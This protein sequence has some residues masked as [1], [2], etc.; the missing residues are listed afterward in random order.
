MKVSYGVSRR[1]LGKYAIFALLLCLCLTVSAAFGAFGFSSQLNARAETGDP[2]ACTVLSAVKVTKNDGYIFTEGQ[3][4]EN[5]I[6]VVTVTVTYKTPDGEEP[7][8]EETRA[9]DLIYNGGNVTAAT[10]EAVA[11]DLNTADK[12]LTA[13]VTPAGGDAVTGTLENITISSASDVAQVGITAKYVGGGGLTTTSVGNITSTDLAVK[14]LMSDGTTGSAL[15]LNADY[16]LG[17]LFPDKLPLENGNNTYNKNLEI[18]T[19]DNKY[20][21]TAFIGGITFV[22]PSSIGTTISGALL[23]QAARSTKLNVSGLSISVNY[24]SEEYWDTITVPL[25]VFDGDIDNENTKYYTYI[26]HATPTNKTDLGLTRKAKFC[27]ITFTYPY[28]IDGNNTATRQNIQLTVAAIAIRT[29]IFPADRELSF[30]DG[31]SYTIQDTDWSSEISGEQPKPDVLVSS[32]PLPSAEEKYYSVENYTVTFLRANTIYDIVLKLP[33]D[34]DFMWR[35]CAEKQDDYTLMCTVTVDKAYVLLA[36]DVPTNITWCYGE[37]YSGSNIQAKVKGNTTFE[38]YSFTTQL[39]NIASTSESGKNT[40]DND[41]RYH[42]E[43]Y[44]TDVNDRVTAYPTQAGKYKAIYVTH[45][46]EI[47][48]SSLDC[49]DEDKANN[50]KE[51]TVTITPIVIDSGNILIGDQTYARSSSYNKTNILNTAETG[52]FLSEDGLPLIVTNNGSQ[53]FVIKYY[54]NDSGYPVKLTLTNNNY[55]WDSIH[56][57]YYTETVKTNRD[58]TKQFK[59]K[60]REI[61]VI[62]PTVVDGGWTYGDPV[63]VANRFSASLSA[64]DQVY[65]TV[66][67]AYFKADGTAQIEADLSA[68]QADSY[69]AVFTPTAKNTVEESSLD[70]IPSDNVTF[71]V[72]KVQVNTITLSENYTV[73][74]HAEHDVTLTGWRLGVKGEQILS[75]T[76]SG[77]TFGDAAIAVTDTASDGSFAVTAAGT[78]TIT[79]SLTDAATVNYEWA[80]EQSELT[81]TVD[82]AP[83]ALFNDSDSIDFDESKTQQDMPVIL[84]KKAV[85]ENASLSESELKLAFVITI[86][87]VPVTELKTSGT[88]IFTVNGISGTEADNYKIDESNKPFFTYTINSTALAIP[89]LSGITGNEIEKPFNGNSYDFLTF[90]TAY[91]DYVSGGITRVVFTVDG[92]E[93]NLGVRDVKMNEDNTAV[94]HYVIYVKPATSYKWAS[95]DETKEYEFH[96][97]VTQLVVNIS[98]GTEVTFTYDGNTA[99]NP[100]YTFVNNADG[101]DAALSI[102][103]GK[104]DAGEYTASIT[105]ITG[106]KAHNY[107]LTGAQNTERAFTV[108]KKLVELSYNI[109]GLTFTGAQQSVVFDGMDLLC[110][111]VSGAV[112]SARNDDGSEFTVNTFKFVHAGDYT[113]KFTLD[114]AASKNY[115]FTADKQTAFSNPELTADVNIAVA[116]KGLLAPVLGAQRAIEHS[117]DGAAKPNNIVTGGDVDGVVYTVTYGEYIGGV[118]QE[119]E[120]TTTLREHTYFIKLVATSDNNLVAGATFDI[121]DY[122]WKENKDDTAKLEFVPERRYGEASEDGKALY[123][124]FAVTK[125]QVGAIFEFK[126]Y[127]YGAN[128]YRESAEDRLTLDKTVKLQDLPASIVEC[129]PSPLYSDYFDDIVAANPDVTFTFVGVDD[130]QLVNGLPWGVDT[131]TVKIS[132]DFGNADFNDFDP[133]ATLTVAPR[134]IQVTW[135]AT[136]TAMYNGRTQYRG[137]TITNLAQKADGVFDAAPELVMTG[138]KDVVYSGDDIAYG[139]TVITGVKDENSCY[140][141]SADISADFKITRKT[142]KVRGNAVASHMYGD[143]IAAGEKDYTVIEEDGNEFYEKD[144]EF[145]TVDIL[146]SDGTAVDYLTDVG[147]YRVVPRLKTVNGNYEL[148]VT[149][150]IFTIVKRN[151]SVSIKTDGSGNTLATSVYG[152][153]LVELNSDD[154]PVYAVGG[155]GLPR[156]VKGSAVFAFSCAVDKFSAVGN[157]PITCTLTENGAKNYELAVFSADYVLAAAEITNISVSGYSNV[158]DASEHNI[159]TVSATT[160]NPESGEVNA[161]VWEYKLA[162]D[163]DEGWKPYTVADGTANVRIKDYNGE[164]GVDYNVRV[165]ASNH[166]PVT[167][168]QLYNVAVTKARLTV[169]VNISIYY[170]EQDP[171]TLGGTGYKQ[172]LA[173]VIDGNGIY[174]VGEFKG[175]D[176][177]AFRAGTLLGWDESTGVKYRY[178]DATYEAGGATG[179][180]ALAVDVSGLKSLNYTFDN[181]GGTLNVNVLPVKVEFGKTGYSAV[182]NIANPEVPAVTVSTD[183][184][185]SYGGTEKIVIFDLKDATMPVAITDAA[186]ANVLTIVNPALDTHEDGIT[187]NNA[188]AAGYDISVTPV[189]AKYAWAEGFTY[190]PVKYAIEKAD[191]KIKDNGYTLFKD[192]DA[193]SENESAPASAWIYGKYDA[194]FNPRGYDATNRHLPSTLEMLCADNALVLT[195]DKKANGAWSELGEVTV[196]ANTADA[197][198]FVAT[199]IDNAW[200]DGL[201]VVGEYSVTYAMAEADNYNLFEYALYFKIDR[202]TLHVTPDAASTDYGEDASYTATVTGFVVN[203]ETQETLTSVVGS[204]SLDWTFTSDYSKGK[205]V[206]AYT[207]N[208]AD[209]DNQKLF[210]NY[211]LDF[212]NTGT[213]TVNARKMLINI[214]DGTNHYMFLGTY[215]ED[216]GYIKENPV[217]LTATPQT[218]DGYYAT[219]YDGV[220]PFGIYTEALLDNNA[221]TNNYGTYAIYLKFKDGDYSKNYTVEFDGCSYSGILPVG[222]IKQDGVNSAGTYSIEKAQLHMSVTGP[223]YR[224]GDDYV[225]YSSTDA[226]ASMY[227]GKAKHY[228]AQPDFGNRID[229]IEDKP[230]FVPTYYERVGDGWEEIDNAPINAGNY[231]VRFFPDSAQSNNYEEIENFATPINIA[232]RVITYNTGLGDG[233]YNGAVHTPTVEFQN[234]VSGETLNVTANVTAKEHDGK[235]HFGGLK[236]ESIIYPASGINK[237][238]VNVKEAGVY[239]IEIA[240]GDG[241]QNYVLSVELS[242]SLTYTVGLADLYVWVQDSNVQYGTQV[243][244]NGGAH[245]AKNDRFDGFDVAYSLTNDKATSTGTALGAVIQDNIDDNNFATANGN[246]VYTAQGYTV[247]SHK[248]STAEIDMPYIVAQNYTLHVNKG[249]LT[250]TAR[251]ISVEIKGAE[252]GNGDAVTVYNNGEVAWNSNH[253]DKLNE[254][255]I[256]NTAK[257]E[258]GVTE[259]GFV[260]F[261]TASADAFGA[262]GDNLSSL[263]VGFVLPSTV[264]NVG[265]WYISIESRGL[266]A[267]YA[268]TFTRGGEAYADENRAIYRITPATLYVKVQNASSTAYEDGVSSLSAVYGDNVTDYAVRFSGWLNSEGTYSGSTLLSVESYTYSFLYG[269]KEFAPYVSRVGERYTVSVRYNKLQPLANYTIEYVDTTVLD[270]TPR[271]VSV[272]LTDGVLKSNMYTTDPAGYHDGVYGK[273]MPAEITF[274]GFVS[275]AGTAVAPEFGVRYDTKDATHDGV[276]YQTAGEAP[277]RV[278]DYKVTVSLDGHVVGGK[279]YYDYVFAGDATS[280]EFGYSVTQR[281]VGFNWDLQ[282]IASTAD[283]K[284]NGIATFR[285]SIMSVVDFTYENASL[286]ESGLTLS[287]SGLTYVAAE[288]GRYSI[289]VEL[290]ALAQDNYRWRDTESLR[291]TAFFTVTGTGTVTIQNLEMRG[292]EYGA[293]TAAPSADLISNLGAKVD[294]NIV[295]MYVRVTNA[296]GATTDGA[297]I[298]DYNEELY[299]A[300]GGFAYSAPVDAGDYVMRASFAGNTNYA[301]AQSVYYLFKVTP[302]AIAKPADITDG[303]YGET[304]GEISITA[305]IRGFDA[306]ALRIVSSDVQTLINGDTLELS[307]SGINANGYNIVFALTSDNYTCADVDGNGRIVV[308]W[309]VNAATDNVVEFDDSAN[310]YI[311]AYGEAFALKANSRYTVNSTLNFWYAL[312]NDGVAPKDIADGDWNGGLPVN[313][314]KYWIRAVSASASGN[315][316]TAY[317]YHEF[318]IT[319]VDLHITPTGSSVYGTL[320]GANGV[321]AYSEFAFTDAD[322]ELKRNDTQSSVRAELERNTV[323]Y[324]VAG[325]GAGVWGAKQY[326]LT[327]TATAH[328]YNVICVDGTFTVAQKPL[329]VTV[330]GAPYSLYSRDIDLS[331]ATVEIDGLIAEDAGYEAQM[332]AEL[333]AKL[334]TEADNKSNV[335]VYAVT[336]KDYAHDNYV[337]EITDGVY[338]VRKL[339]VTV[340]M[341]FGGYGYGT[342]PKLPYVAAVADGTTVMSGFDKSLITVVYVGLDE[343]PTDAGNY[344]VTVTIDEDCNYSLANAVA[345]TFVITQTELD[346]TLVEFETVYYDGTVKAPK[347]IGI[348]GDAFSADVFDVSYEGEW[349]RAGVAY[350]IVLTLKSTKNTKWINFEGADRRMTYTI[351]R[352]SNSLVSDDPNNEPTVTITGWTYG[353]HNA[354]TNA[355][356]AKT[357][358]GADRIVYEYSTSGD[359]DG[360]WFTDIASRDAGEYYV[361]AVVRET[362]DYEAFYSEPVKFTVQKV[363]VSVPTLGIASSGEGKNDTYTGKDMGASVDGFDNGLMEIFYDGNVN[364]NGSKVTVFARNAGEYTVSIALKNVK[365]Y[366]WADGITTDAQGNA[367]LTWTIGKQKVKLPD[368]NHETMIVNGKL[369]EYLPVGFDASIMNIEDNRS[370]YGGAF[371]AIVTL[372]DTDNYEWETGGTAPKE[373]KFE[374]VGANTVF[375]VVISVMMGIS[376]ALIAVALV[377]FMQY[378][379]RKHSAGGE[380]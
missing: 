33:Q 41:L 160:V 107:T 159:L 105:D 98:W 358:F 246:A 236:H 1:K 144:T 128:G 162:T 298:T 179:D 2:P 247:T 91:T 127:V 227:D 75:K 267:D 225:P 181:G 152:Q 148:A 90:L 263:G 92:K 80:G 365:N 15:T 331:A 364:I 318:E 332:I 374:I 244:G 230:S 276:K 292:W 34:G 82:R 195:L 188:N 301:S 138:V 108:K 143:D 222:A 300:Q 347:V 54:I 8:A 84:A 211:T 171:V 208:V 268:I 259:S 209:N 234:A 58:V 174:T 79:V 226:N 328:N 10:G 377:Q 158:Y 35:E 85:E 371:T 4:A 126:G 156:D 297:V 231:R 65:A 176:E 338:N 354:A 6:N 243:F 378:R 285:K 271:T 5:L 233:V 83:V 175:G 190:T 137:Y 147:S 140:T 123:L 60:K 37:T 306:N 18:T 165:K 291:A 103:A 196:P 141:V 173:D 53:D 61:T 161:L 14:Q 172:E 270:I 191:N 183:K 198:S 49:E 74:N 337:L 245:I 149:D 272:D 345:G 3:T 71:T 157:Y 131:Y 239:T 110:G 248:D 122:E 31:V 221:K 323:A 116:R 132:V 241:M 52:K 232:Q 254:N 106:D 95:G 36:D 257:A 269:D 265:D 320:K 213:L 40:F 164:G 341:D 63:T 101:N 242:N 32:T 77:K 182:Y 97:T 380:E 277:R 142:V 330:G 99:F 38:S 206:G 334:F 43:F 154:N 299:G 289:T 316:N 250:V 266:N 307:A 64:D 120:L 373:Y 67:Q 261:L 303:V 180:Y 194:T 62:N 335:G 102:S 47:Y 228:Q 199:L 321:Y 302:K 204:S 25:S 125:T 135:D 262:S 163:G 7:A 362:T 346:P 274:S 240:L 39:N 76:V 27:D 369:L 59:I 19:L 112:S 361:R 42:L 249:V 352:G 12:T 214:A 86:N 170:G 288:P 356:S 260:P 129:K 72:S 218:R 224:V 78:Y 202:K 16:Y 30:Y 343:V 21:T 24:E 283:D 88:Y 359:K 238:T 153:D 192:A 66:A 166:E 342:A 379:K 150:G 286:G 69:Y 87:G 73:Y 29:P 278:G 350:T 309:I 48:K 351:S 203:G 93:G 136:D 189:A 187:T 121:S 308:K 376:V 326:A 117:G 193:S 287:D 370:A 13:T 46:T 168:E 212:S 113:V 109:E 134:P 9:L 375:I 295:Y 275:G 229:D 169:A 197:T 336:V 368:D 237:L 23:P 353:M 11:F 119:K 216:S 273:A 89:E 367:V 312:R 355:P 253:V 349:T 205:N 235:T 146:K 184:T 255:L 315:Y 258:S 26:C 324:T 293:G 366:R 217:P 348:K 57:S 280:A 111:T 115:C 314:D 340:I 55:V 333:K 155:A 186:L 304:S 130:G 344:P 68:W 114:E 133:E 44:T 177:A 45:E 311:K 50:Y 357:A 56:D 252:S 185:S 223:Y 139:K 317:E 178:T 207:I 215:N 322:N 22:Q 372:K 282:S 81:Y 360:E 51:I 256:A 100:T 339:P 296:S 20:T 151:I 284:T 251:A 124:C 220:V 325:T 17:N 118:Y 201:F 279:T 94:T 363:A 313:A 145:V 96:F 294:G 319:K 28:A 210:D 281:T 329:R 290:T 70:L 104:T 264:G 200:S 310:E 305:A 219:Y 167:L 327:V